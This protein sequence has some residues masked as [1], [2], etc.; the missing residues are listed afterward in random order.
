MP[1]KKLASTWKSLDSFCNRHELLLIFLAAVLV[2]RLPNF[3]E[4]YWYGD[5]AIYLTIGTAMR[6]GLRLYVQTI[7]HKTPLIYFLA[8]V[9]GQLW[10][11]FLALAWSLASVSL[12]W[13][14]ARRMQ[15]LFGA[16]VSTTLFVLITTLPAL[17]G[18]IPN[19][20]LFV[21]GFVLFGTWLAW[22]SSLGSSPLQP[23]ALKRWSQRDSVLTLL[24][25]AAYGLGILTKVPGVLDAGAFGVLLAFT[26]AA[27]TK[28]VR[29]QSRLMWF[30]VRACT[31]TAGVALVI[32]LSIV[33]FWSRGSLNGYLDY[34]LLY[35]FRYAQ[36]WSVPFTSPIL[37]AL[38]SL[39][40]KAAILVAVFAIALWRA[41][42]K[43]AR[44][45]ALW[46]GFWLVATLFAA[47]LSNRPYPHYW[48][49]L[50]AP[51]A[52]AVGW[53]T[54]RSVQRFEKVLL[55]AIMML[56]LSTVF[57]FQVRPYAIVSYYR[58]YINVARGKLDVASYQAGFNWLVPQNQ[59]LADRI[60]ATTHESD[61]MFVWGTNPMLYAQTK[62]S[63]ATPFTVAFHIHGLKRYEA[64][65][66]DLRKNRPAVIVVMKGEPELPGLNTFL[67]E[68]YL[69]V[70]GT[71][72]MLLYERRPENLLQ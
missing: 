37:L 32:L 17:E 61:R 28:R 47:L 10:F 14:L 31:F 50:S 26:A 53:L 34:G 68:K 62:R 48:L 16:V 20:E 9:P 42:N 13:A 38:I 67:S 29:W 35:N 52:L 1:V 70:I 54:Q 60:L 44:R 21:L 45:L 18:H 12:F 6:H 49:Q 11:R 33:Y 65:M 7:D 56:A 5:E 24:A 27:Q 59:I 71:Q 2:L 39:P 30:F 19:G 3:A 23:V 40:G 43:P 63:P 8:M 55:V 64:T 51:L 15:S 66:E 72:D 41:W 4:P 46:T 25:G 22:H 69:P 36:D 57:L 58:D